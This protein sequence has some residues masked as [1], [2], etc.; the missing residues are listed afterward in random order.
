MSLRW[1]TLNRTGDSISRVNNDVGSVHSVITDTMGGVVGN[2]I[3]VVSTLVVMFA[4]DWR[5]TLF[6]VAFVPILS[7][8]PK[9]WVIY[10]A[11]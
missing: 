1:F 5:L 4:I 8:R 7:F 10:S 9:G 2:I 3:T 11:S 6:S